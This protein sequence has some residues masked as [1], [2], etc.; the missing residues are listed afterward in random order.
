MHRYLKSIGFSTLVRRRDMDLL[1]MD[2]LENY[3]SKECMNDEEGRC[4]AE[5]RKEYAYDC[6]VCVIGEYDEHNEFHVEHIEPYFE[7]SQKSNYEELYFER[8]ASREAYYGACDDIRLG[9]TLI[10]YLNNP[11]EYLKV[12]R[13]LHDMNGQPI[14]LSG[15]AADG[16]ILLP[17]VKSE[18]QQEEEKERRK[19]KH[20]MLLAARDGNQEAMDQLTMEDID[21]Y[22]MLAKRVVKEDI[23]TIVDS[24][25]MPAGLECDQY[26]IAGE[27]KDISTTVNQLSG[28]KL[29]ELSLEC[30]HIKLDVLINE[31]QLLGEPAIGRRF[32]GKIWLQGTL[33][34]L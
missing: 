24:C 15:L 13:T 20:E 2:V 4:I 22:T 9:I 3:D 34:N 23:F 7:G 21:T 16:T 25:F 19:E 27:I 8:Q 14:C 17:L 32:K 12:R 26:S 11:M 28:E 30:N 10:F 5:F 1:I 31:K 6:G 33:K 18:R 29:Y